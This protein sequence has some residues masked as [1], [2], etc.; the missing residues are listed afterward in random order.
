MN[1]N[2]MQGF[3]NK[4]QRTTK[5]HS[6]PPVHDG[7]E[8]FA[9]ISHL[10]ALQ[11]ERCATWE[12]HEF[13]RRKHRDLQ[14]EVNLL[15]LEISEQAQRV[16]QKETEVSCLEHREADNHNKIRLLRQ[17]NQ[18]LTT[19]LAQETSRILHSQYEINRIQQ[20]LQTIETENDATIAEK[21]GLLKSAQRSIVEGQDEI[22]KIATAQQY[23]YEQIAQVGIPGV[24]FHPSNIAQ[25]HRVS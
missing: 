19:K 24:L 9:I 5:H 7:Q 18:Y 3:L 1:V 6:T 2:Q 12:S 8:L 11:K 14:V 23:A 4:R 16:S 17:E 22:A 10:T 25:S 21:D 15:R 13:H 20:R